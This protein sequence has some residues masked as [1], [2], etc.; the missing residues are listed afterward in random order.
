MGNKPVHWGD[1]IHRPLPLDLRHATG[2]VAPESGPCAPDGLQFD[3]AE[4][5]EDE[6][7][8]GS[9]AKREAFHGIASVEIPILAGTT[10]GEEQTER[11]PRQTET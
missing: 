3:G 9:N 6:G 4:Q 7:R 11:A 1:D 8:L 2:H 10:D 5:A